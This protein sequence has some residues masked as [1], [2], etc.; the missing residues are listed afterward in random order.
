MLIAIPAFRLSCNVGI[1]RGRAWSVVDEMIL[2]ATAQQ[3]RSIAQLSTESGLPRQIIVASI[4]R[5]MRFRLIE[6]TVQSNGA[7]FRA[8]DYGKEVV[9]SGRPLPFFPKREVK[10]VSFVIERAT[11]SFFPTGQ[12]RVISETALANET[13]PDLRLVIVEGG[14]PSMSHEANL[15][16][17]S[18][19]AARGW[20][21]QV[22][23][24]DGRTSS[25]RA[26]FMMIRVVDGVPRN[27][28]ESA[29]QGLRAV[30]DKA[31]S[32]PQGTTQV[33]VGYGGS[34]EESVPEPT[35]HDCDFDPADI[36]VG[37]SAQL[38]FLRSLLANAASRVVVHST[39]LDHRRFKDLFDDIRTACLRGV[40]FDMLWGAESLDEEETRNSAS[41]VEIA[42]MV[43]EDRD[44]ARRFRVHM[45]S[46]GSHAKVLLADTAEGDWIAAVGS[47]NW[48]STPFRA[49]ELT[50]ILRDPAV[51]ADVA[52]AMQRMVG[53]RGLSDD[54]ATEMAIVA[55]D[56]RRHTPKG[57]STKIS[58]IFGD[59][60]D[61][62]MRT[63][64]GAADRRVVVGSHRLGS[65][66]RPG[67]VIQAE[68]AVER[69]KVDTT[70]LYTM[71]SGPLRNRHARTL[72]EEAATNGVRLVK[73]GLIPLHGKFVAW[74]DD[75]VVITS[76]NWASASGDVDFPQADIGVHI[77][78]QGIA[79]HVINELE[80]IFPEISDGFDIASSR[81][82]TLQI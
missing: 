28:P 78:S 29:S 65:T 2:W 1:D 20:E 72:A 41:A 4:A 66:A 34:A 44:V 18:Q 39:F 50:A 68:A 32:L 48:L 61:V 11:G 67:V 27:V 52:V 64:S 19:I 35:V 69:A 38:E 12:V 59:S 25:L 56:L 24:V 22:A 79:K 60:H 62:M 21:E 10:R 43:R 70:L 63:A 14:G 7:G 15:S 13:D 54:I 81:E 8:S 46:T 53:R 23:L 9:A 55:R 76:L 57:G 73:T 45:R 49:V 51:V 74:D 5:L 40:T 75:N 17:L 36:I 80:G 31:A 47:C 30:I 42:K 82:P 71:P 16:R 3:Q 6:L 33:A 37:G 58:L 26:E 77:D